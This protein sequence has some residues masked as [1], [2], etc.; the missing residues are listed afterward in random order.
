MIN[1][2]KQSLTLIL[3]ISLSFFSINANS[4][5]IVIMKTSLGEI[6]LALDEEKAPLSV[7]NFIRY[8]N[9]G[10]YDN[11][12]FHRVINGFMAQGGG[13][14]KQMQK[15]ST[16]DAIRNEAGNG[17]KNNRGTLAMARTSDPHSATAQFFINLIDN[18]YLNHTSPS[19]NWGYAVFGKV[20]K[21]MDIV[22]KISEVSVGVKKGMRNVPDE[23][24]IIKTMTVESKS[25]QKI[26]IQVEA[27]PPTIS[28]ES[29]PEITISNIKE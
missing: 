25:S 3:F 22:D 20:V 18:D 13:Y 8:A 4:T 27:Q 14:N 5:T 19:E 24:V 28:V 7:A 2:F 29:I 15:K 1:K 10:F 16:H 26:N 12:I 23:D 11:T 21:G 6:K 9:E 17:L